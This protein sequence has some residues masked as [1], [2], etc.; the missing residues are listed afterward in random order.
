MTASVSPK[1]YR[2]L[3]AFRYAMRRFLRFSK[4]YLAA[5][6]GLTPEQYEALLALKVFS[7]SDGLLVGQ[8]SERLQVKHHTAVSLT[9]KL[10]ARKLVTKQRGI[11]DRRQVYVKLTDAGSTLLTSMARIHRDELHARSPEMMDA[12]GRLSVAVPPT[13][14]KMLYMVVERFK[15][16]AASEVYRR[17]REKGRMLPQGLEYVASWID[18]ELK[19]CW[20]VMRTDNPAL[21]DRW[22][23]NWSD[24]I[25]FEIVSVRPS[26]EVVQ[27]MTAT[28]S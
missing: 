17:F 18:D 1:H 13:E 9:D 23:E 28:K 25:D 24:L 19:M 6:A 3:A 16:G 10:A 14:T 7:A 12:L 26:A 5:E 27:M 11:A 2:A 21:F 20:Q 8:L 15:Q 4:E 22:T